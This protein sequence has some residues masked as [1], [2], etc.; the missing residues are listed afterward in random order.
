[1]T[2]TTNTY[3][4]SA[5]FTSHRL[6]SVIVREILYFYKCQTFLKREFK[7]MGRPKISKAVGLE[8]G[9]FFNMSAKS[10]RNS[11]EYSER[12]GA[13]PEILAMRST[14]VSAVN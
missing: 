13:G 1:M 5:G 11:D 10:S 6:G 7:A 8:L 12:R 4:Y 14:V 9:S 3:A 2:H